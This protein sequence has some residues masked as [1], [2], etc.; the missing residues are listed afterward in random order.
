MYPQQLMY[1]YIPETSSNRYTVRFCYQLLILYHKEVSETSLSGMPK[2]TVL[3]LVANLFLY[4]VLAENKS[5]AHWAE[6]WM[7]G[8]LGPGIFPFSHF[9]PSGPYN[10][11]LCL[12]IAY[13]SGGG[14]SRLHQ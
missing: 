4:W 9:V 12:G 6:K 8:E 11:S 14:G 1:K 7:I 3:V 13:V 2:E 5:P 10:H